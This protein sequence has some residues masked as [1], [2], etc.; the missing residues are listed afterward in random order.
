MAEFF[1]K[2]RHGDGWQATID[3]PEYPDEWTR[4]DFKGISQEV[5]IKNSHDNNYL[6]HTFVDPALHAAGVDT[7]DTLGPG[8]SFDES[9]ESYSIW[10][11]GADIDGNPGVEI[12]YVLKYTYIRL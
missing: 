10:V 9:V 4:L 12:S 7:F 5:S 11:R 3:V 6:Q 1:G 2:A 8:E